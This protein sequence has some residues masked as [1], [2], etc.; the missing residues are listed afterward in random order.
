MVILDLYD[1]MSDDMEITVCYDGCEENIFE[2]NFKDLP[3][4]L[5]HSHVI[6]VGALGKGKISIILCSECGIY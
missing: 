2:G 6:G 4:S 1:V 5:A 3:I